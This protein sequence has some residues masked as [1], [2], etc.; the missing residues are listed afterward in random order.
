LTRAT[1]ETGWIGRL[2]VLNLDLEL[3]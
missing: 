3:G 1:A 2:L